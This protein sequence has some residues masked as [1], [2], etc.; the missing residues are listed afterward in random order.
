M[1]ITLAIHGLPDDFDEADL[2]DLCEEFGDV[3]EVRLRPA[4]GAART[5]ARVTYVTEWD[6]ERALSEL[7]GAQIEG[8]YLRVD[9][10]D[11]HDATPDSERAA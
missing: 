1:A 3:R 2:L 6:A 9:V 10:V 8:G 7:D 5:S 4:A 11:P